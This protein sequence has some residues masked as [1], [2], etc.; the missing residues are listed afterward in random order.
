MVQPNVWYQTSKTNE[1]TVIQKS[2]Q[3]VSEGTEI[4]MQK[5]KNSF[6]LTLESR[7]ASWSRW[8]RN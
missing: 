2:R 7:T 8:H 5:K 6:A 4:K 3:N 1:I